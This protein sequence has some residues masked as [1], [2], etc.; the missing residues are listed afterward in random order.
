MT[1]LTALIDVCG[2]RGK[3]LITHRPMYEKIN[4]DN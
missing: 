4:D 2:V 3:Y 1:H